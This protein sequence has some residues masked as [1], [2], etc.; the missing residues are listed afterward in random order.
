MEL[1]AK[2]P[3]V[4]FGEFTETWEQ[5][6]FKDVLKSHS[7][8]QYLAEPQIEGEFEIIQQ[9]GK[10]IIGYAE[11]KPFVEYA[12]V[13]LFGDHTVS[14]YKPI[15]PFFVATDGVKILSADG[16]DGQY[17]FS[18]LERYKPESQGYKRHYTILKNEGIWFTK[19]NDEQVKI[20]I[21]FAKLDHLITLHQQ[22]LEELKESK[23]T[24]LSKMFPKE[25]ADRPEIRF[26]GFTDP[27]K[28]RKLG[29]ET[30]IKSRIGWQ[31]LT[32]DEQLVN[33]D[34]YLITG[35]DINEITHTID[36]SRS[37]YVS[38]ERY[39]KD[40]NIQVKDGDI[41]VTKDGTIGKIAMITNLDKP[42]TLNSHLFVLRDLSNKIN[43]RFLLHVLESPEFTRF[44]EATKTGSTL[45]GLP[46]K[47]FINFKYYYPSLKE[48]ELIAIF[49]DNIDDTIYFHQQELEN[50]KALKK[51]LLNLMFV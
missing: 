37:V 4:R 44:V 11:G 8:R 36:Y 27:W 12:D 16:F 19:N 21:F 46:Q 2:E 34:Y 35:T 1:E 42:A 22:E 5:C 15:K 51:T 30:Y 38:K 31:R 32:K 45:T 7:F 41:I 43:N 14:L 13:T 17:L 25:G 26:A 39:E 28:E 48:Q 29:E 23:K 20:G 50:L 3:K 9:G 47:T 18:T 49:I 40:A 10:P 24:L 6:T 33:G